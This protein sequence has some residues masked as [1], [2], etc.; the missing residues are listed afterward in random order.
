[1]LCTLIFKLFQFGAFW[2]G[3][4]GGGGGGV[5]VRLNP[6]GT[7]TSQ[8]QATPQGKDSYSHS[9]FHLG[10]IILLAHFR[11]D[12]YSEGDFQSGLIQGL[13]HFRGPD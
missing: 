8:T 11:G 1:M 13:P 3:G 6:I 2:G 9:I 5:G 12:L 10:V 7:N 4:G